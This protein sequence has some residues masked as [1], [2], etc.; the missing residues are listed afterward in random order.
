[1]TGFLRVTSFS[2]A[3]LMRWELV[4]LAAFDFSFHP[5]AFGDSMA[6]MLQQAGHQHCQ[7]LA[8]NDSDGS[9]DSIK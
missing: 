1:M 9:Q 8:E 2:S 7:P 5:G 3:L 6:T 4:F